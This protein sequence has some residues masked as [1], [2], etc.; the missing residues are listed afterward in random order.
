MGRG[1]ARWQESRLCISH[2]CVY[3]PCRFLPTKPGWPAT[4]FS[5]LHTPARQALAQRS[6]ARRGAAR[7]QRTRHAYRHEPCKPQVAAALVDVPRECHTVLFGCWE[8]E[9]GCESAVHLAVKLWPHNNLGG[10]VPSAPCSAALM[11]S[12]TT[13]PSSAHLRL[14]TVLA[15]LPA[16]VDLHK[17]SQRRP[18][19]RRNCRR[20][21]VPVQRC[22]AQSGQ[23]GWAGWDAC[24]G[25]PA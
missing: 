1:G 15:L 16:R 13:P 14:H 20:C 23:Q 11:H 22:G 18:P 2:R 7:Q 4:S 10:R 17:H 21:G 12:R 3:A 24:A 25:T 19:Q 5:P 9:S 6:A 8:V